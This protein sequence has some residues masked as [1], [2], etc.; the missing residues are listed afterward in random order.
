[1]FISIEVKF[2][3][4]VPPDIVSDESSADL[5]VQEGD[6]ATL[7]C[8]ATGNPPPRVTWRRDPPGSERLLLRKEVSGKLKEW[9]EGRPTFD[10]PIP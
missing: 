3:V 1:M 2:F 9:I 7:Y 5:S 8:R 4:P 6:N 10:D